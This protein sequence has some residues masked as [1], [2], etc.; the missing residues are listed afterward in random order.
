MLKLALYEIYECTKW[1]IETRF[2]VVPLEI[3]ERLIISHLHEISQHFR[4][5]KP[6]YLLCLALKLLITGHHRSSKTQFANAIHLAN[7]LNLTAERDYIE[8]TRK[9]IFRV[10]KKDKAKSN[11]RN[12]SP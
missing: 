10:M 5:L 6:R 12:P 1:L 9:E 8:R 7:D 3:H 11:N 2:N 4:I